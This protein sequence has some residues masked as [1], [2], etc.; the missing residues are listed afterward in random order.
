MVESSKTN[1]VRVSLNDACFVE[2]V[3]RYIDEDKPNLLQQKQMEAW[4]M[5]WKDDDNL[6]DV[7][8]REDLPFKPTH[9]LSGTLSLHGEYMVVTLASE[10]YWTGDRSDGSLFFQCHATASFPANPANNDAETGSLS[11]DQK[12][13]A[14]IRNKVIDRMRHDD[15]IGKLLLH[16][17]SDGDEPSTMEL[18][19]A[20]I[21]VQSD[22]PVSQLEERVHCSEI[23]ADAIRRA[24][25]ATAESPLDVF[26][27]VC[28]LPLLPS[29]VYETMLSHTTALADRAKL[30]LL[31]DATYDA[32]ENEAEDELVDDL[33][34]LEN[35][36]RHSSSPTKRSKR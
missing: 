13:K 32:C 22:N 8:N 7:R 25:F 2:S 1:I 30:R 27:L 5:E 26:D 34:L 35:K 19:Q 3:Q 10:C 28:R 12:K 29:T 36:A 33:T 31:E 6:D 15:Y 24:V 17:S 16:G 11:K 20:T 18:C 4:R 9:A 14:K 23:T 21:R